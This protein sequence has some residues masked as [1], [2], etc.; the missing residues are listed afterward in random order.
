MAAMPPLRNG[1]VTA[2]IVGCALGVA[3][4][5]PNASSSLFALTGATGVCLV[6]YVLP[7]C[8]HWSMP[9]MLSEATRP[10]LPSWCQTLE[11][12]WLGLVFVLGV[13]VSLLSL[14]SIVDGWVAHGQDVV[15]V[16]AG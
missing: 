16:A 15:C 12:G 13:A 4:L 10:P 5:L 7:I 3:L 2:A 9:A 11:R 6:A 8:A 1:L 14:G